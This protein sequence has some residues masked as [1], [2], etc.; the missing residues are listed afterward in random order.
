M[1]WHKPIRF[2]SLIL[3]L[4]MS[5]L[6]GADVT[7]PNLVL[8]LVDDLGYADLA[9]TGSRVHRTPHLDRLAAEGLRF[10]DFHSNGAV[11]S[12]TRAALLTGRY[13]QRFGLEAAIGFVR[14]EGVPLA[15][16]MIPEIL[17]GAGYRSGVF[18]KWHVGHVS[19]FGPNDQGFDQSACANNN[20]DYHSHISRD[21]NLDWYRDQQLADE[22]GYLVD[23]VTRHATRFI[24]EHRERPFFLYVPHLAGHFPYQGRNDPAHRTPGRTWDGEDKYGPLPRTERR[25]AYRE[26]I[27]AVDESVGQIMA[28]LAAAGLRE[29]TLVFVTSDNGGYVSVS[30]HGGFRGEKGDLFE[31]GHRVPALAHWPGRIRPGLTAVTAMTADLMPT[32]LALARVAVPAGLRLD[33]ADLS[34]V[35]LRGEN[36]PER[37]LFWRDADEQAVR[38]GPWKLVVSAAGTALFDL[39][40][41]PGEARNLAPAQPER[42]SKLQARLAAW[43]ADVGPRRTPETSRPPR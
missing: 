38:A 17:R 42:V 23:V 39:E 40:R 2:V 26:M 10:T 29:R 30:D 14:D 24:A 25:R 3:G 6:L 19:R 1:T 15:A 41:D 43:E 8:I 16:T 7:R 31:G 36:L 13:P 4:G 32:F 20:P 33:G 12:P 37:T 21:G 5:A 35:L 9:C 27:E 34:G 18:G 28:A 22:P 11:C